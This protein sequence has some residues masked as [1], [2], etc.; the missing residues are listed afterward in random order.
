MY[1]ISFYVDKDVRAIRLWL[2][3]LYKYYRKVWFI[4]A[5]TIIRAS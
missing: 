5:V 3:F 4:E 1:L 2:S